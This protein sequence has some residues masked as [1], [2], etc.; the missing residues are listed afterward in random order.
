M[1]S[2]FGNT[3]D[4]I[5][6]VNDYGGKNYRFWKALASLFRKFGEN[7]NLKTGEPPRADALSYGVHIDL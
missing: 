2:G 3:T 1:I 5:L 4:N 6:N 7:L